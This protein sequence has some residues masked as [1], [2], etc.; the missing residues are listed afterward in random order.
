MEMIILKKCL[1]K[2]LVRFNGLCD[3]ECE[4]NKCFVIW[5][6]TLINTPR[7]SHSMAAKISYR[8]NTVPS[9]MDSKGYNKL[10][11]K[12][13][14]I[15]TK[16]KWRLVTFLKTLDTTVDAWKSSIFHKGVNSKIQ[17]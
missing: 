13:T 8:R 11:K 6:Q 1:L 17:M 2:Y 4:I 16:Q 3:F 15:K 5:T 14:K 10:L 7:S 9:C 12:K